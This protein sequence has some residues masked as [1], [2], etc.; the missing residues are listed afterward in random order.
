MMFI[1]NHCYELL[2]VFIIG[3]ESCE[4]K[5][6]KAFLRVYGPW[7]ITANV[8]IYILQDY[9]LKCRLIMKKHLAKKYTLF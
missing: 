9:Q 3:Y 5:A 4:R 2:S 7:A 1:I 8:S 6:R